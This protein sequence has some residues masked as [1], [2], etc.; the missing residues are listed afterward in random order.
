RVVVR[1][2]VMVPTTTRSVIATRSRSDRARQPNG[3][4]ASL[5]ECALDVHVAS[6]EPCQLAGYG[7]AESGAS[8]AAAG[9]LVDLR[10][11]LEDPVHLDRRDP[12]PGVA[13]PEEDPAVVGGSFHV[14]RPGVGELHC[15]AQQVEQDLAYLAGVRGDNQPVGGAAGEAELFAGG[16]GLDQRGRFADECR[17]I[18]LFLLHFLPP[19]LDPREGQDLLDDLEQVP[20]S[21]RDAVQL[22]PLPFVE[23]TGDLRVQEVRV[24]D[25]GVQRGPQL[26]AHRREELA[27][28]QIRFLRLPA[29]R[30]HIPA[31]TYLLRDVHRVHQ[32]PRNGT[33]RF[34][35]G[36]IDEIV[37]HL[38]GLDATIEYDHRLVGAVRFTR[39]IDPVEQ[40]DEAL[41]L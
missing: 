18:D 14:D 33:I 24:A 12:D 35:K 11:G 9:C 29:G 40:V 27:L 26:V 22:L 37:E 36:L 34:E 20:R 32:D 2:R 3:E 38:D 31:G 1:H 5:T 19:R 7:E 13:D 21:H 8:D 10:E 28:R 17:Q 39:P 25:D 30:L 16:E 6:E 23:R 41:L 15:V 4:G